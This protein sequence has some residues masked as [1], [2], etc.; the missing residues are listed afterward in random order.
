LSSWFAFV[1]TRTPAASFADWLGKPKNVGGLGMGAGSVALA[2]TIVIFWLI[3]YLAI[4]LRAAQSAAQVPRVA[5]ER[6]SGLME[7]SPE[8]ID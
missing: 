6:R 4:S 3:S 7:A 8:S 5:D 1:A 2:L